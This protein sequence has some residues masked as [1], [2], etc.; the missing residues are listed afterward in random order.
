MRFLLVIQGGR[1]LCPKVSVIIA[2]ND[3][4]AFLEK[5][6]NSLTNQTLEEIEII[7]VNNGSKFEAKKVCEKLK[8]EDERISFI[9]MGR[10][11]FAI[12]KYIA[13]KVA[14]GEYITFIDP[15]DWVRENF[16]E[17]M[18]ELCESKKVDVAMCK[19]LIERNCYIEPEENYSF[20]KM[21]FRQATLKA[22]FKGTYYDFSL[23]GKF[24]KK[25][26][27]KEIKI[28]NG[29]I[30]DDIL[31]IYSLL[32]N[33]KK[34][35]Y[36]NYGGYIRTKSIEGEYEKTELL[37]EHFSKILEN[38]HSWNNII[39]RVVDEYDESVLQ[40]CIAGYSKVVVSSIIDISKEKDIDMQIFYLKEIDEQIS[41]NKVLIKKYNKLLKSEKFILNIFL[42]DYRII[43]LQNLIGKKK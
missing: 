35:I 18:Y 20:N 12:S 28:S 10:D 9:D 23:P 25:K 40:E 24:F 22:C 8:K 36:I 7:C 17:K 42:L 14:S 19:T 6:I 16:L 34:S 15:N 29:S 5:C 1:I 13:L 41:S 11:R 4:G 26:L 32:K 3:T 38:I 31:A 37:T 43:M 2:I 21:L 27:F 39:E 33:S 30:Y